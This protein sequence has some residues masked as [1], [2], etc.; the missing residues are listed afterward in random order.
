MS[1]LITP[2]GIMGA[3]IVALSLSNVVFIKL[4]GSVHREYSKFQA[5]VVAAQ[6]QAERDAEHLRAEQERVTRDVSVAWADAL[7]YSREHPVVR[8][9]PARC[10]SRQGTPLPATGLKPDVATAEPRLGRSI[11]IAVEDCEARLNNAAQDAAMLLE[12]Q[13]WIRQQHEVSK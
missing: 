12:L 5:E 8:V 6:E 4:Y 9:L 11:S 1:W 13:N 3:L 2:T 7:A 10:D